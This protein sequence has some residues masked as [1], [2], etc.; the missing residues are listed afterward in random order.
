[1][2]VD[3]VGIGHLQPSRQYTNVTTTLFFT[4]TPKNVK[5][6]IYGS[7]NQLGMLPFSHVSLSVD[8]CHVAYYLQYDIPALMIKQTMK[9]RQFVANILALNKDKLRNFSCSLLPVQ[10]TVNG[11]SSG[12]QSE[13]RFNVRVTAV[14]GRSY[15]NASDLKAI[16]SG[17]SLCKYADDTYLIIPSANVDSRINELANFQYWSQTNLTLNRS[18]S[19]EIVFT[20]KKRRKRDIHLPSPIS[21]IS[22]VTSI[23]VLEVVTSNN[24]SVCGHMSNTIASCAQS[25]YALRMAIRTDGLLDDSIYVIYRPVVIAKLKLC[26]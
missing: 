12:I 25:V 14:T 10:S 6:A 9:F 24:L 1:M 20:A 5:F 19:L 8:T 16:T 23:K 17:N 13:L 18:K 4:I 3:Q 15:I 22:R 21:N 11:L 26:L 2:K 7:S